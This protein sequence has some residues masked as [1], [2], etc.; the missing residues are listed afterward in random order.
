MAAAEAAKAAGL[1]FLAAVVQASLVSGVII[2]GG[3]P[4]LLLVTLVVVALLRGALF[5]AFCGFFAGLIVDTTALA[6]L[7][8]SSLLLTLVGYWVGRYGETTGRDP[9]HAPLVAVATATVFYAAGGLALHSMVGAAPLVRHVL[10]DALLPTLALNVLLTPI[11]YALFRRLFKPLER[12]ARAA[13]V[14]LLG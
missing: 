1:L 7:G 10:V 5:G 12:S 8:T 3:S 9:P 4:D 14:Q 13:E 2:F 11:V 6:V